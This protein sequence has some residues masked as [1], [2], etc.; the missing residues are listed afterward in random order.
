[1]EK[2]SQIDQQDYTKARRYLFRQAV[3]G[4]MF[5]LIL[6]VAWYLDFRETCNSAEYF[7]KSGAILI[8]L[9]IL[10]EYCNRTWGVF[11]GFR[12]NQV[13]VFDET[14]PP[15]TRFPLLVIFVTLLGTSVWAFGNLIFPSV[16]VS[17]D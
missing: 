15:N 12:F 7:Q 10:C 11:T 5:A 8:G 1:M 2:E 16:V 6:I 9:V 3:A 14:W 17:C 4:F 13:A